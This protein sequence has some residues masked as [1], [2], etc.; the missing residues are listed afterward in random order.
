MRVLLVALAPTL[1]SSSA[2]DWVDFYPQLREGWSNWCNALGDSKDDAKSCGHID[3]ADVDSPSLKYAAEAI[4]MVECGTATA[5][6]VLPAN[7]GYTA[8]HSSWDKPGFACRMNWL[9]HIAPSPKAGTNHGWGMCTILKDGRYPKTSIQLST[10]EAAVKGQCVLDPATWGKNDEPINTAHHETWYAAGTIST[11]FWLSYCNGL[12]KPGLPSGWNSPATL[13]E[14]EKC[15]KGEYEYS[16]FHCDGVKLPGQ[17][18]AIKKDGD[19]V[20]LNYAG[21]SEWEG[22]ICKLATNPKKRVDFCG[23]SSAARG[24][25]VIAGM[26]AFV[27]ALLL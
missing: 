18:G 8:H 2:A 9:L 17:L 13:E 21:F 19:R 10:E 16:P 4:K 5:I 25:S 1:A 11:A 24:A 15:C 20:Q 12:M 22:A 7:P 14:K 26:M 6:P 23:S 3:V 27:G